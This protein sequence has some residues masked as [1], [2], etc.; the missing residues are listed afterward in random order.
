MHRIKRE[1]GLG[2]NTGEQS[3]GGGVPGME[4][5]SPIPVSA[6]CLGSYLS[7]VMGGQT[8]WEQ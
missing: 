3:A 4:H 5:P 6:S 1:E 7:Q 8:I 2:P